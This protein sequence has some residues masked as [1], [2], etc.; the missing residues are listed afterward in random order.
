MPTNTLSQ[1]THRHEV[2]H[3]TNANPQDLGFRM[4]PHPPYSPDLAT[5]DFFQFPNLKIFIAGTRKQVLIEGRY[6]FRFP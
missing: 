5:G 1:A 3:F 2:K 6:H 4:I